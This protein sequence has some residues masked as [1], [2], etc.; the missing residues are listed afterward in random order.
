MLEIP[1]N[2][3]MKKTLLFAIAL[4]GAAAASQAGSRFQVSVGL[5]IPAPVAVVSQPASVCVAPPAC[6]PAP[7]LVAPPVVCA[8]PV[9]IPR[10]V[11]CPPVVAF[12]GW[13]G[14]HRRGYEHGWHH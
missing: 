13:W 10:P 4:L 12:H 9:V 1:S 6:A 11:Y 8:P 5:G 14:V 7:V 3:R 2:L